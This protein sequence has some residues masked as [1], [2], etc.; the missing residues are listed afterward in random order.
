[1]SKEGYI[2]KN[3]RKKILLLCDD[4]RVHSGIAHIGKEI[5]L[6]SA[7]HYNWVQMAG[8]VKHPD[9][10]KTI[11]LSSTMEKEHGLKDASV[12]LYPQ[13]GYGD[14]RIVR[15]MIKKEK[16][17]ALM[18]ITDPRYFQ[19]VFQIESEIRKEIPI[20]YLNIWDDYPAPQYNEE[21]YESCDALYGISK[22][23][24]NINKIVLGDNVKDK[25]IEYLPHGI[26]EEIF[27]PRAKEDKLVSEMEKNIFNGKE[28]DFKILFNSRNIRRKQISDTIWAF[29][30]FLDSLPK[31][32]AD[33]CCLMMKTQP[34]D[35][36]GTDLIAVCE[37]L[38]GD[39]WVNHIFFINAHLNTEQMGSLY[40][41]ADATILLTSNEGWGLAL[42]ESLLSGTPIIA[43]VTG[44]MQDQMRFIDENGKW[45]T[46]SPQIPSNNTRK[47]ETHGEWAF[48]VFPAC[49]SLQGSPI[50]PYIWDDR[51]KPED[52]TERMKELYEMSS[53]ERES[54]GMKGREW[55]LSEEAGFTSDYQGKRFI[56]YTDKLFNTWEPRERYEF[57]NSNE[58]KVRTLNHNLVY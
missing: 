2:E 4:I 26:N 56:E 23:T 34:I 41:I 50:T 8:A 31:E 54:R 16:P 13:D 46:P 38:F 40:N 39:S 58:Y 14:S 43:N 6:K 9:K 35:N 45:F 27:K 49:R 5:V 55:A 53:E 28:F 21:Y 18:L 7:H 1:M 20:I 30:M 10:G 11:D 51:C 47:Y 19:F 44:G 29:K 3:K 57:L 52:A 15:D 37:Y 22:Q 24:V 42:T 12:I 36:N 25:V 33:K 32:K 17:D 48:P